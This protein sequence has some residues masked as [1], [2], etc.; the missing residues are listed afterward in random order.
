MTD[1]QKLPPKIKKQLD[2]YVL[3]IKAIKWF[4]PDD[5]LDFKKVDKQIKLSLKCFGVEAKIEY[6]DL[7]TPGDWVTAR[8]ATRATTWKTARDTARVAA[9]ITARVAARM[10]AA[11]DAAWGAARDTARVAAGA[12][13]SAWDA[14]FDAAG[15]A[16]DLLALNSKDYKKKYP[17]GNFI[18]LIPLW[19][20]GLYPVGIVNGVFL[21]Y[22][23]KK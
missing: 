20:M 18:N 19:E 9:W 1:N 17:K 2:N 10:D 22:V 5:N 16:A 13:A 21:C 6:R 15:G 23:P 3:R 12:G 7:K 8:A 4:Q 11:W 14:A